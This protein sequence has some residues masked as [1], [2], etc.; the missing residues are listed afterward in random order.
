M[1]CGIGNDAGRVAAM[2]FGQ[3][4]ILPCLM[5]KEQPEEQVRGDGAAVT[6]LPD[7]QTVAVSP[8]ELLSHSG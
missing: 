8:N 7:L 5:L 1:R 3:N 6:R 4:M 2:L